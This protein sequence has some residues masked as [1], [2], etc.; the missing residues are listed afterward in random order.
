MIVEFNNFIRGNKEKIKDYKE[1]QKVA[2]EFSSAESFSDLANS[3]IDTI[4]EN[5]KATINYILGYLDGAT[6]SNLISSLDGSVIGVAGSGGTK[7]KSNFN[8]RFPVTE[9]NM[10]LNVYQ[11]EEFMKGLEIADNVNALTKEYEV[12]MEELSTALLPDTSG[13]MVT[14]GGG[15]LSKIFLV[16]K[17]K[18]SGKIRPNENGLELSKVTLESEDVEDGIY[19]LYVLDKECTDKE[20]L[21]EIFKQI[22]TFGIE[23]NLFINSEGS[24]AFRELS[25]IRD[26]LED[27]EIKY[28]KHNTRYEDLVLVTEFPYLISLFSIQSKQKR[29]SILRYM[30]DEVCAPINIAPL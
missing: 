16:N 6:S 14:G 11:Y 21:K 20:I 7:I 12:I 15:L 23:C 18:N 9:E 13:L 5:P 29:D 3:E 30:M 2:L 25:V 8:N 1:F 27:L 19:N 22:L 4:T 10:P 26:I 17:N 24:Y 28:E